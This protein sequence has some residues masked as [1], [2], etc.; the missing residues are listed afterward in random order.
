VRVMPDNVAGD[1]KPGYLR[2]NHGCLLFGRD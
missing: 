2:T 1:K